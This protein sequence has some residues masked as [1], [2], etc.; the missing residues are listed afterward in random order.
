M[1]KEITLKSKDDIEH[2]SN[3]ASE[4]PYE[5]YVHSN[6]DIVMVDARSLLA[7]FTLIGK[8]CKVVAEDNV[9]PKMFAKFVRKCGLAA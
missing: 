5:V 7:L 6:D 4:Q 2:L 8:R 9:D 3:L 1:Y